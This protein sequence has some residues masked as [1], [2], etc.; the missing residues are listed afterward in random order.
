LTLFFTETLVIT[1]ILSLDDDLKPTIGAK[2]HQNWRKLLNLL[3][4]NAIM[5]PSKLL[6]SLI[7]N[8]RI[9]QFA[10]VSFC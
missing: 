2:L 9:S 7:M 3:M 10:M 4:S 8:T 6:T 5:L 1:P